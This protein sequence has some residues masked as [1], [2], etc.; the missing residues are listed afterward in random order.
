M[1]TLSQG[2]IDMIN[3][4]IELEFEGSIE[5]YQTDMSYE[6]ELALKEAVYDYLI[7]LIEDDSLSYRVT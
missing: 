5:D 6:N 7:Q 3:V 1:V 2:W 4:K